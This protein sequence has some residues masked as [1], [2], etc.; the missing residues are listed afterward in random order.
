MSKILLPDEFIKRARKVHGDKF[1]YSKTKY[2]NFRTKIIIICDNFHEFEQNPADHL[3]GNGCA[4]CSG[5]KKLDKAEFIRR[6]QLIHGIVYDYS[7]VIYTGMN[8]H[9]IINCNGHG[10][11]MQ[12]PGKHIKGTRC[13]ECSFADKR[14]S[15]DEF[16]RR[17]KEVHGNLYNYEFTK[18]MGRCSKISIKCEKHGIFLQIPSDHLNGHGC[19]KCATECHL[20]TQQEFVKIAEH[21][22]GKRFI[23]SHVN[24]TYVTQKVVIECTKHGKFDQIAGHHLNGQGCF[25]CAMADRRKS[26]DYS[27]DF[28]IYTSIVNSITS[29]SYRDHKNKI[30]PLNLIRGFTQYHVDHIYSRAEGFRNNI[31]PIIIGHWSNLRM[32]SGHDNISKHDKCDKTLDKLLEDY[33]KDKLEG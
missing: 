33:L 16:I 30:N 23:Y 13:P 19:K 8:N 21:V 14:L 5:V 28:S 10:K 22:H 1:D 9:V 2:K 7:E 26:S 32:L 18:Y 31:P 15:N 12:T 29:V 6:A 24:T 27:K 11:F 4:E 25:K 3:S 17:A 20:V